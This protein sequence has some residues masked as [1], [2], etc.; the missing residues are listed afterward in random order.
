MPAN[1]A[2]TEMEREAAKFATNDF[3]RQS[4]QSMHMQEVWKAQQ[5]KGRKQE[6]TGTQRGK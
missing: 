5:G 4:D 3:L 1:P 2:M 6:R